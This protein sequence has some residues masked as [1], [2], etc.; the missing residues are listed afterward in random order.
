MLQLL[1][2]GAMQC[3]PR[4]D[5]EKIQLVG[6]QLGIVHEETKAMAMQLL[7]DKDYGLVGAIKWI[8]LW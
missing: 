6:V 3:L 2:F 1:V 7:T 4:D 5:H 8:L